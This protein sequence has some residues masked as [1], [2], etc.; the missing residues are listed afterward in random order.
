MDETPGRGDQLATRAS[1]G[2][3]PRAGATPL[4]QAL[5]SAG[6][7]AVGGLVL[8]FLEFALLW[9][10]GESCGPDSPTPGCPATAH[11]G[12]WGGIALGLIALASVI[13]GLLLRRR[14]RIAPWLLVT[15]PVTMLLAMGLILFAMG[16]L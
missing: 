6:L 15:G 14:G 4:W 16:T 13:A 12:V 10:M 2:G 9:G 7:V 5:V 3:R 1:A 11:L 8:L